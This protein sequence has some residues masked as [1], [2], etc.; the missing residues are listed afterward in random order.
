MK[1]VPIQLTIGDKEVENREVNL[2]RYGS[3]ASETV[4]VEDMI[5]HLLSEVKEKR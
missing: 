1:K 4:K 2:R 3:Q 5:K